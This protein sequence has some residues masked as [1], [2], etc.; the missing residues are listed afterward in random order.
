MFSD[1]D[2]QQI[3]QRGS[4]L[5]TVLV[6]IGNFKKGFPFLPI[7]EAASVGNGIIQLNTENLTKRIALFDENVANGVKPLKFVPASGAASRMFKALFEGLDKFETA[8]EAEVTGQSKDVKQYLEGLDKFA[9]ADDLKTAIKDG[10]VELT[11]KTKLEYLLSD[12][13]L[14]YGSKPKGLLKFHSYNA[15]ARTPFEEHLVEGAK[16]ASDAS[17]TV[18]IHFTVSPEHQDGFE[19]LLGEV[20]EKY[21]QELGVTFDI[22]FSQQKPATDTIAV[23]LSNEPFRNPDDSLLFRP[24]GHGA[25]IENLN[26]L[27]AD[28]IFIKNID[29]VV[30]DRLK[31]A[32]ID[33][34]KALAGVL[35]KHQLKLFIYQKELNEKH[36]VALQSG[37]LAEVANFLENT[38]NTKPASNQ[39]YTEKDELYYYLKEK[40]N[41]PLRVCGMVR[42]EGEP[43]GGPF[44]ALNQDG[45]VSLQVVESSQIDPESVQQQNIAKNAT[46]FNPVDLVCA[47]KNYKGEKYDLR[48]YTD[49]ET[50]FISKKSKDGKE[51]KAQ[52]LPGLWNGAMSN[53][54]TLFVEVPIETFNPVKT[55]NDLLR[56]Q[57]L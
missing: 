13:G 45:T 7:R 55:V 40:L 49:P 38:L 12:K 18:K 3:E 2:K 11:A 26:D 16:Y 47:V 50:G 17:N 37:F 48:E 9:F 41:R 46:H 51:L 23:D 8:S 57:H 10:G 22:T 1:K 32:T 39:Y 24:A 34:K 25:L 54:N 15:G 35:L 19:A 5:N 36:P 44:W 4:E 6:Q 14:D 53:W 30:P 21:E 33:Y 20:K 56:E 27:D 28:I 31:K 43:G 29:N 42:N 52:E